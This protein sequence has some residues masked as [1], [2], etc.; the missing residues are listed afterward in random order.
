MRTHQT[1]TTLDA[2]PLASA[3]IAAGSITSVTGALDSLLVDLSHLYLKARNLHWHLT[4][5]H[6]VSD[7]PLDERCLGVLAAVD[8][9]AMRTRQLGGMAL[10]CLEH[11]A[12]M[13]RL[14]GDAA[15][16][17]LPHDMLSELHEEILSPAGDMHDVQAA[18][19][20]MAEADLKPGSM[21]E[22]ERRGRRLLDAARR[23]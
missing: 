9:I 11:I 5:T 20:Q 21:S 15:W 17:T 10:R 1:H 2:P 16:L 14:L 13:Q 22:A 8:A 3:R 12:R 23:A 19:A 18:C 6:R 4:V 7:R